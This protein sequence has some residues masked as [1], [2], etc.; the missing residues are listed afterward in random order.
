MVK[1]IVVYTLREDCDKAA[2]IQEIAE[3]L[4]PLVGRIPGLRY[5]EVCQTY[6]GNADY[7]LYS[8]FESPEALSNYQVHPDH[9]AA[10]GIVHKYV[11]TRTA[12]DYEY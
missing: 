6:Q 12:A 5:L 8:E 9:V 10:K 1:H 7:V 2:A 3:A 11:A 4:K